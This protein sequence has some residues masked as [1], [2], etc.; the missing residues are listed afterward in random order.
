MQPRAKLEN[1]KKKI[2]GLIDNLKQKIQ[3]LP[4]QYTI[5]REKMQDLTKTNTELGFKHLELGNI[6][7]A[8]MRFKLVLRWFSPN[9]APALYGLGLCRKEEGDYVE[10]TALLK[11]AIELAD[12]NYP[13]AEY[14]LAQ[15]DSNTVPTIIPLPILIRYFDSIAPV[16]NEE[17]LGNRHYRVPDMI[18]ET[19][20]IVMK[21]RTGITLLDLGCGT[22]LCGKE[23]REHKLVQEIIGVDISKQM[24]KQAQALKSNY[25]PVYDVLIEQ[26]YINY[27]EEAAL[28]KKFDIITAALSFHYQRDIKA[29]LVACKQVLQP[30]GGILF[31]VCQSSGRDI[32]F[33]QQ[34]NAFAFSL[35]YLESQAQTAGLTRVVI[36]EAMLY[37]G[38]PGYV[39]AFSN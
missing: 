9:H 16:F 24:L 30:G 39:C 18:L 15:I 34:H 33:L 28:T 22:G 2:S 36:K 13:E 19:A 29:L 10:A 35:S 3:S 23:F 5:I 8:V 32:E 6:S 31:S 11:K 1:S 14:A 20:A 17:F 38:C 12:G 27:L 21:D 26:N 7:D 4:D 37:D 25:R